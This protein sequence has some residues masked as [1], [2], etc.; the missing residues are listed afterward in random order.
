MVIKMKQELIRVLTV[1][2]LCGLIDLLTPA[3]EREGL[4]RAVRL[5]T[6]LFLLSVMLTPFLRLGGGV[7]LSDLI[8]SVRQ[9]E[10]EAQEEY[11]RMMEEKLTVSTAAQLEEDLYELLTRRLGLGRENVT[12]RIETAGEGAEWRVDHIRVLLRGE[13][14]LRDPRRVEALIEEAVGCPCTAAWE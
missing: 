11:E 9:M 13:A 1:S 10:R 2:L 6:G 14:I 12:V 5:L 7:D 3:G 8:A 4:R